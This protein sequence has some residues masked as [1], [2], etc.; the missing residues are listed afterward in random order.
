MKIKNI[1]IY[2][3]SNILHLQF[4]VAALGLTDKFSV[5]RMKLNELISVFRASIKK[6]EL[7]YKVI[8]KSDISDL[9]AER[10]RVRDELVIGMRDLLKSS[11]HHFDVN[12]RNAAHR[13]KIVFDAYNSP[14]PLQDLSYDAETGA[15]NNL[16]QDLE[17]KDMQ[18][19]EIIGMKKW[20]SELHIRNDAF[21]QLATS[22]Y[23]QQSDKPLFTAQEARKETDKAYDDIVA[24][25]TGLMVLDKENLSEYEDF[26]KELNRFLVES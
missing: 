6:E 17:M 10:D 7:S 5:I 9:K 11:L 19:V 15:I 23:E 3:L 1:R 4:M 12:V 16:L 22:Y 13:V 18:D 21:D 26:V 8:R 24:A 20:I 25:I 2:F 14:I